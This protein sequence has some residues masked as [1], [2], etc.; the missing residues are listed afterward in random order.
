MD[1]QQV[2]E[3]SFGELHFGS[4]ELGDVAGRGDWCKWRIKW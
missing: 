3:R 2:L 1:D 4:A